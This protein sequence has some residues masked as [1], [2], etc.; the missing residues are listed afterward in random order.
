MLQ[1]SQ[2][3]G[4]ACICP[5]LTRRCGCSAPQAH[6]P[7]LPQTRGPATPPSSSTL[8][9]LEPES[10]YFAPSRASA[11][12][13]MKAEAADGAGAQDARS[14]SPCSTFSAGAQAVKAAAAA[15][16]PAEDDEQEGS[17]R[18]SPQLLEPVCSFGMAYR[19][20]ELLG[21]A[22]ES[23]SL[24][25]VG[26][27]A[28]ASPTLARQATSAQ[29]TSGQHHLL[30]HCL[31]SE[32]RGEGALWHFGGVSVA[33][34]AKAI[35]KMS[36]RELQAKF[37]LVYN[38]VTH[39]NNNNWL[40]RKL[41][42]AIGMDP[43]KGSARKAAAGVAPK[44]RRAAGAAA[45]R[46]PAG[47]RGSRR[48]AAA[49][50]TRYEAPPSRAGSWGVR[51]ED[52]DSAEP[53]RAAEALLALGEAAAMAEE[54]EEGCV[55][56]SSGNLADRLGGGECA[57]QDRAG[58]LDSQRGVPVAPAAR[59]TG[60]VDAAA[61]SSGSRAATDLAIGDLGQMLQAMVQHQAAA[62]PG[63]AY[64]PA[65]LYGPLAQQL[66]AV[67]MQS[68]AMAPPLFCPPAPAME[69]A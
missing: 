46:K 49:T 55:P 63:M 32:S 19:P 11:E 9:K 23:T 28:C 42:E 40:R 13:L 18:E 58:E 36:Q 57:A 16:G 39:S 65:P 41:F 14:P 6:T 48:A 17:V 37:R 64:L 30:R 51:V 10:T 8:V 56:S 12:S 66:F 54:S 47:G 15:R 34:A 27:G 61:L 29:A 22:N 33:E 2:P 59:K 4:N 50:A 1:Q 68:G 69:K 67:M 26:V 35:K 31:P 20:E 21:A 5:R 44:R 62:A 25:C 52:D 60:A 45:A 53:S 43:T 7:P 3:C 24:A 38:S